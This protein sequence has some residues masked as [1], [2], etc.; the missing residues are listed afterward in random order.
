MES[1]RFLHHLPHLFFDEIPKRVEEGSSEAIRTR[2][3][4][5]LELVHS[6]VHLLRQDRSKKKLVVFLCYDFWH[7]LSDLVNS[8]PSI[9]WWFL[10]DLFEVIDKLL[11]DLSMAFHSFSLSHLYKRDG[12]VHSYLYCS[13]MEEFGV[14]FALFQ[15]SDTGFLLPKNFFLLSTL[16]QLIMN[17]IFLFQSPFLVALCNYLL[18]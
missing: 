1:M 14:P 5:L 2:G 9:D 13:S 4:A 15:P 11:F 10:M 8:R 3:F 16:L 6:Q 18:L 7:I 12:V 17:V